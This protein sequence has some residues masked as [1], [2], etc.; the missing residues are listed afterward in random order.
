MFHGRFMIL[1]VPWG[2]WN[3]FLEGGGLQCEEIIKST[4]FCKVHYV[5]NSDIN[6]FFFSSANLCIRWKGERGSGRETGR[7]FCLFWLGRKWGAA[8][9]YVWWG[10]ILA[11]GRFWFLLPSALAQ[12]TPTP[13][14]WSWGGG[15]SSIGHEASLGPVHNLLQ[16][17]DLLCDWIQQ[18][19]RWPPRHVLFVVSIYSS[20][21]V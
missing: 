15:G 11:R 19:S 17:K 8:V 21:S 2:S 16:W 10:L 4:H 3:S 1:N 6:V 18:L 12:V 14:S 5:L 13:L 9:S 20:N 7:Y